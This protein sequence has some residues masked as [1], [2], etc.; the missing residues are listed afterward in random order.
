MTGVAGSGSAFIYPI[1]MARGTGYCRV[2][3]RQCEIGLGGMVD[4]RSGPTGSGMAAGA[5]GTHYC[6]VR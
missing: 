4:S 2:L 6:A 1:D 5:V 3:A